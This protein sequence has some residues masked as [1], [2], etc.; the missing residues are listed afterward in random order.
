MQI[1]LYYSEDFDVFRNSNI[2]SWILSSRDNK[3]KGT[4][5]FL[6]ENPQCVLF[7]MAQQLKTLRTVST[8]LQ[9]TIHYSKKRNLKK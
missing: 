5:A 7:K 8:I 4:S 9:N 1:N 6:F 3:K 2:R